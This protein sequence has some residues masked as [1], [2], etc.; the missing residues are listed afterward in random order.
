MLRKDQWSAELARW[1]ALALVSRTAVI[2][3]LRRDHSWHEDRGVPHKPV[4]SPRSGTRAPPS[5]LHFADQSLRLRG[6]VC[7]VQAG[8]QDSRL[9]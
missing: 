8:S 1:T 2:S 9:S 5:L 4:L 7:K 3:P 6:L